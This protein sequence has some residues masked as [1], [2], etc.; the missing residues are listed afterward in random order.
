MGLAH[1]YYRRANEV[2]LL[3]LPQRLARAWGDTRFSGPERRRL[4]Y[5]MWAEAAETAEG[6]RARAV[7]ED[8]IRRELPP[9]SPAAFTPAELARVRA[10]PEGAHFDPYGEG[11]P[12]G[13]GG[14]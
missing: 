12:S 6:R 5:A 4:L 3:E 13:A 7:I 8:F 10:T 1:S 11:L 14:P 9:G 2:A